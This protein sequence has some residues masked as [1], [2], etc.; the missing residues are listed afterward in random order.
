MKVLFLTNYPSPYKVDF[1]N[2]LGKKCDLTVTFEETPEEQTHRNKNWFHTNYDN[3]NAIFLNKIRLGK[4]HKQI[5]YGIFKYLNDDFDYIIVGVYSTITS[6]MAI[7]YMKL[8]RIRFII[9]SDGGIPKN[10]KNITEKFKKFLISSAYA[11]FS[12]SGETDKYLITYGAQKY[13]IIRYPF[14]TL[15][16]N[17]ILKNL[18]DK[19][20][21]NQCRQ[22]I[23]LTKKYAIV[24]I[25]QFIHRKGFD[26]LIEAISKMRNKDCA[27][28][29]IGGK[30]T[31]EYSELI[32][33]LNLYDIYFIDFMEQE[34]L[35]DYF[36]AADIFVLP[37]RE[38]IWGLVIN[39]AM[40]FGLP[41]ITTNRCVAGLEMIKSHRDICLIN[42]NDAEMLA[43]SMDTLLIDDS[44]RISLA[45]ENLKISLNYTI[46]RMADSHIDYFKAHSHSVN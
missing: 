14:T 26:I 17:D 6:I 27:F 19:T 24:T 32:Q 1:F 20:Y 37:T 23:K 10:K 43:Q 7:L 18:P 46:E 13:N 34:K 2:E 5:A 9:E 36:I 31:Q 15:H 39:E 41:V 44:L 4:P 3:F 29:I 30:P 33:K 40:A 12:P 35:K 11:W 21:V 28:Y 42:I 22:K 16:K 25:G 8:K 45:M 38:D